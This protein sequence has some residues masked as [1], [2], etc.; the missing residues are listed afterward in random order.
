MLNVWTQLS[1]YSLGTLQEQASVNIPLPVQNDT[2]V[3]YSVISG[4]LPSGLFLVNKSIIGSAFSVENKKTYSVCIRAKQGT[5]ISDRT[6]TI[7]VNGYNPPTFTT[8]AGLLPVGTNQQLYTTDQTYIEYKIQATDLNE[9]L[10]KKI[11]YYIAAGDG[12]LPPGLTLSETGVISGYIL[13]APKISKAE[14]SGNYDITTFDKSVYDFGSKSTNGFDSY[15]Y[16]DVI[17]DYA[18]PTVVA[19]TLSL[20][21]QFRVTI[22]DGLNYSQRIFKIFVVGSDDFRADSLELD[23]LAS[24]FTADSSYIRRPVW[25]TKSDLGLFRA[26]NYLT[27][28]VALYDEASVEFRLETTNQEVSAIGYQLASYD[29]IAG[30]TTVSIINASSVPQIGQYF[31]LNNYVDAASEDVYQITG[32]THLTSTRY[33]LTLSSQLKVRIP[34]NTLFYIGSLSELPL[35]VNFDIRT[36]DVYGLVPYQPAVSKK[37]TFTITATRPGDTAD[38]LL[39]SSRTFS[40]II[41]GDINSVITWITPNNLGSIPA[42]YN[43]TLSIEASTNVDGSVVTYELV[44]GQ[45]PPGLALSADG[46]LLG[47]VTQYPNQVKNTLGLIT[48]D[49]G[50]TLFDQNTTSY[51][52]T[53]SFTVQAAD[54]YGYSAITRTFTINVTTP[55]TVKYN[56]VT[57]RPFLIPAQR[58]LWNSFITNNSVFPQESIYRPTDKNFGMQ[59]DLTMLVYAGIETADAAAYVGAMGL[60]HKRKRFVFGSVKKATAFD[61]V[62]NKAVYEVVYIQMIDPM[63]VGG[64]H[65]PSKI[66]TSAHGSDAIT[67]DIDASIWSRDPE[68]LNANAPSNSRPDFN[69]T[70]DSTGYEIGNTYTNTYFPNSISNWQNNLK[71]IVNASSERNYLPLWMRSIQSGQKEQLGYVLAVPLCFCKVGTADTILLNIK[72]S[73]FNFKAIDYTIDRFTLSSVAGYTDDKYL[74]FKNDRIT[75]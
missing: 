7:T 43:C 39:S 36:G 41:L 26:N 14:G 35:G 23:S 67:V 5:Q 25:I 20:N 57:A 40:I 58:T 22:T 50:A 75:V 69:I 9:A 66:K 2:G 52:R 65:L 8:P 34:N 12:T 68:D 1:G 18:V 28:P 37:Y 30:S 49:G 15:K 16:D 31:T 10:S 33:R 54:Q 55:N 64:K 46:E 56:N 3:S 72:F 48:L 38:D 11:T 19:Q 51:D 24:N 17:F 6:F 60:N 21:Y 59:T 70:I 44:D 61:P 45:L 47:T 62:T 13:P 4:E 27:V 42:E 53:Y 63:E 71:S 32:V 29:N 73:N 74:I